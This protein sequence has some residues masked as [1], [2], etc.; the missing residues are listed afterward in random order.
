ME[1]FDDCVF[2]SVER[3][4]LPASLGWIL[5]QMNSKEV[6]NRASKISSELYIDFDL[7]TG[8]AAVIHLPDQAQRYCAKRPTLEIHHD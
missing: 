3:D 7:T 2:T 6:S 8:S 4:E 1:Q 5:R